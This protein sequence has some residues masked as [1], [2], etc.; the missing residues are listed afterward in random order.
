MTN[1]S[2]RQYSPIIKRS[3]GTPTRHLVARH[4]FLNTVVGTLAVALWA[5]AAA[6]DRGDREGRDDRG[7][8]GN[9]SHQ[10]RQLI[11]SQVGGI[12]KLKVPT[13]NADI[14]VPP[15]P[16]TQPDRYKTTEAKRY[17]GKLL[18]HDPVRTARININ[19][20]QPLDLPAGTAFGGTLSA[21]DPNIQAITDAQLK[22]TSCGSCHIGEAAG[23]AG[24]QVNFASGGEGRGYTDEKGNFIPRR[25]PQ[26]ILSKLRSQPIFPGD[27][28]VDAL[29]TLA[30]IFI[31]ANGQ[32]VVTTPALFY[33]DP[34]PKALLATG[35]LDQLD[36]VGRQAPSMIGFAFNNR[37]LFGGIG[38]E[39][40]STPGSLNPLNET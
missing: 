1:D 2:H 17:L 34:K 15:G 5:G 4:L 18:F 35:R 20:G 11:D 28:L 32:R 30:D 39:V 38:G 33:H 25:R 6:A 10:L 22:D 19:N 29:P 9:S 12:D 31:D 23:K 24:Q 14:P 16:S 13:T 36:S 7:D 21:S 27:A 8:H 40:P 37:L 26:A 3:G